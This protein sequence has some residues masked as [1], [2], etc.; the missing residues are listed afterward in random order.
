MIDCYVICIQDDPISEAACARLAESMP[1]NANLHS[2]DAVTPKRVFARA[3]RSNLVWNYPWSGAEM[4][5]KSGL[6]KTAYPTIVKEKR[7]ACF[8]SHYSLWEWCLETNKSIIIHEHDA[9]YRSQKPLPIESF[10][11]SPYD[12]IGLNN[13]FGATRRPGEYDRVVQESAGDIVKA[14]R[15]DEIYVPQGLAGNSAYFMKPSGAKKMIDLTAEYGMWPNDALMCRQLVPT[16]GQ[17]K[18]YYTYV[19]GTES[20]TSL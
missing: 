7:I 20:T 17:T 19:Q 16:L 11:E 6:K 14:P 10:E 5:V 18:T 12:I 13:P 3:R 15:I 8:L 1:S 4:D 9:I 2:F